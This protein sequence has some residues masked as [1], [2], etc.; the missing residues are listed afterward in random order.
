MGVKMYIVSPLHFIR[1]DYV[2][3]PVG[4]A[5][6]PGFADYTSIAAMFTAGGTSKTYVILPGAYTESANCTQPASSL[7]YAFNPTVTLN[8]YTWLFGASA[9]AEGLLNLTGTGDGATHLIISY[10]GANARLHK[11]TVNLV[12]TP[13]SGADVSGAGTIFA[14]ITGDVSDHGTLIVPDK[15]DFNDSAKWLRAVNVASCLK[16]HMRI[17][18]NR[19]T[20]LGTAAT[21]GV[22]INTGTDSIFDVSVNYVTSAAANAIGI[23]VWNAGGSFSLLGNSSHC[24]VNLTNGGT[25]ALVTSFTSGTA[26]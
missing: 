21:S 15:T 7:L 23:N 6:V 20:N 16:S 17:F 11:L 12:P 5:P 10:N 4:T 18:I 22:E 14:S 2:C 19:L 1:P 3:H 25:K 13:I 26:P 9:Y 8:G 24:N